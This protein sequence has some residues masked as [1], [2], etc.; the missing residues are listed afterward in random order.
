MAGLVCD[1]VTPQARLFSG[2]ATMVTVPGVEGSMGFLKGHVPLVSPLADGMVRIEGDSPDDA[3]NFVC[4]GGYV[5]VTGEKVIVL[6]NRALSV[7]DID[8]AA[9]R[10]KLGQYEEKRAALSEEEANKTTLA[11]DIAWC[12]AQLNAVS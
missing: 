1:I 10:E 3:K 9:V 11:E 7:E 5:E 12:N 8:A 6:A 4:Q 2:D